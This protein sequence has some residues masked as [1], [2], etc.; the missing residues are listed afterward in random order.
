M[1]T[2][3]AAIAACAFA[4][5]VAAQL[6]K[7]VDKDGKVHYSDTPPLKQESKTIA[8]P[9]PGPVNA[10]PPKSA[11]AVDKELD[12]GRKAA[13]EAAK[14]SEDTA[15]AAAQKEENCNRAKANLQTFTNSGRIRKFNE[16]G[17]Q[18]F[19]D[20]KELE[21]GREKARRDVDEA[22]KPA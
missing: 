20:D 15:K 5:P 13:A 1:K 12:K 22:C 14:K 10:T 11:V 2:F 21:A 19:L 17:E 18:A 8:T 9:P 6:Y 16:K 4:L 3:F 7:W